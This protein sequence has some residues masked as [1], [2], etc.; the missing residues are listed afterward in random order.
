MRST[1]LLVLVTMFA[2][3]SSPSGEAHESKGGTRKDKNV[4]EEQIL[5]PQLAAHGSGDRQEARD[6]EMKRQLDE[7]SD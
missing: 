5:D 4:L 3:C 6:A 2:G 7:I 1:A